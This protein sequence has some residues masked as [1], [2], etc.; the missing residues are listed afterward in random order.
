MFLQK[1]CDLLHSSDDMDS[2]RHIRQTSPLRF[3]LAA[4]VNINTQSFILNISGSNIEL[5]TKTYLA[6]PLV[7]VF[8]LSYPNYHFSPNFVCCL[9]LGNLDHFFAGHA[10]F[11]SLCLQTGSQVCLSHRTL[12]IH[13][14]PFLMYHC[15]IETS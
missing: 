15:E 8:Y 2:G 12:H 5:A 7:S 14:Q 3:L 9:F 1:P 11:H 13:P 10:A 4:L 6:L